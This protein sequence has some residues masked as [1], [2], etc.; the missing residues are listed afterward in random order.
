MLQPQ[1]RVAT[2]P[3]RYG[4][5]NSGIN[6]LFGCAASPGCSCRCLEEKASAQ[7]QC[8]LHS[9]QQACV[10]PLNWEGTG[11]GPSTYWAGLPAGWG[12]NYTF[13]WSLPAQSQCFP[14]CAGVCSRTC[15]HRRAH[16][17]SSGTS[18]STTACEKRCT[19]TTL[20]TP[21]LHCPA[22]RL[23]NA[24]PLGGNGTKQ[25]HPLWSLTRAW[26]TASRWEDVFGRGIRGL[27][28][29]MNKKPSKATRTPP[30]Y[31]LRRYMQNTLGTTPYNVPPPGALTVS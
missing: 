24:L 25:L 12:F 30:A 1:P 27:W 16:R 19:G 5:S 13:S 14:T 21:S 4:C 3:L 8:V 7:C 2:K 9:P 26:S 17:Q 11:P 15:Q 22:P 29:A 20:N 10:S 31:R 18:H 6:I 23:R 28:S